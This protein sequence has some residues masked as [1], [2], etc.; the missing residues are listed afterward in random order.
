MYMIPRR[1]TLYRRLRG[2]LAENDM[3]QA[4]LARPTGL[5][6]SAINQRMAGRADWTAGQMYAVMDYFRI[7]DDQLHIIFPKGGEK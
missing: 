6:V 7:P 1:R 2:L 5:S 4:D 3:T